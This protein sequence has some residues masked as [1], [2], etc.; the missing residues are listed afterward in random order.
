MCVFGYNSGGINSNVSTYTFCTIHNNN[1]NYSL[2]E[3][4]LN[5]LEVT[6]TQNRWFMPMVCC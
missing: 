1:N 2:P 5:Q 6:S 3:R 4:N